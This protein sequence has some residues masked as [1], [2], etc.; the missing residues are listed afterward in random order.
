MLIES[1]DYKDIVD[2][3]VA[4]VDQ[5]SRV[6]VEDDEA[7]SKAGDLYKLIGAVK[8]RLEAERKDRVSP[9][10]DSV[11]A[12]NNESKIYVGP[13]DEGRAILKKVMDQYVRERAERQRKEAEEVAR[14][15]E[16]EA[17][18]NAEILEKAGHAE[19]ADR[20]VEQHGES[21]DAHRNLSRSAAVHGSVIGSTTSERRQWKFR[22]ANKEKVPHEFLLVDHQGLR[23]VIKAVRDEV[24][25]EADGHELRGSERNNFIANGMRDKLQSRISG[26]EFYEESSAAVR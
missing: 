16:E 22:V 26:I 23:E 13:L 14:K 12:I 7:L 25:A 1:Q 10:N 24:Q 8:S 17:L 19:A 9:L 5:V 2:R 3:G 21:A 11:K 20:V 18:R 15:A 6:V 4:L